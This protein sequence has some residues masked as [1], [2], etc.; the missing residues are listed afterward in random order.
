M[1]NF[2]I[3]LCSRKLTD[4]EEDHVYRLCSTSK[5]QT[6]MIQTLNSFIKLSFFDNHPRCRVVKLLDD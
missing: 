3:E 6:W 2:H 4:E 1:V 5:S